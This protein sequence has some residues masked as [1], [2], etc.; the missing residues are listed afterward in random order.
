MARLRDLKRSITEMG[1]DELHNFFTEHRN[2]RVRVI[3]AAFQKRKRKVAPKKGKSGGTITAD[4]VALMQ[5]KHR[6][7]QAD[8]LEKLK[9]IYAEKIKGK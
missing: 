7:E 2:W 6:P 1:D 5:D 8:L 9:E 3:E 4:V